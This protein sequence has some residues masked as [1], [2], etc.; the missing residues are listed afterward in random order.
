MQK[1][2]SNFLSPNFIELSWELCSQNQFIIIFRF[3]RD[4]KWWKTLISWYLQRNIESM[5]VKFCLFIFVKLYDLNYQM[6]KRSTKKKNCLEIINFNIFSLLDWKLTVIQIGLVVKIF[7]PGLW[8]FSTKKLELFFYKIFFSEL[9]YDESKSNGNVFFR[10]IWCETPC[11]TMSSNDVQIQYTTRFIRS[12]Q[13]HKV[14]FIRS[15]FRKR[16]E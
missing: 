3:W 15:V 16:N 10:V 2:C 11:I 8:N 4:K 1:N 12:S 13:L 6:K 9:I 5:L 14:L 7:R